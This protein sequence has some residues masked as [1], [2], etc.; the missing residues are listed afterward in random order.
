MKMNIG[1]NIDNEFSFAFSHKSRT[2]E[3]N[4]EGPFVVYMAE[5]FKN[6]LSVQ[7]PGQ[8]L[9]R[10]VLEGIPSTL[11]PNP[12]EILYRHATF[13]EIIGSMGPTYDEK[14][15]QKQM[16]FE[17]LNEDWTEVKAQ[18]DYIESSWS[19]AER[20]LF[21]KENIDTI[22]TVR[23]TIKR[24]YPTLAVEQIE[25]KVAEHICERL[26]P[27]EE[28]KTILALQI[29]RDWPLSLLDKNIARELI[30]LL[31]II[32]WGTDKNI[33]AHAKEVLIENLIFKRPGGKVPF[34]TNIK[35]VREVLKELSKSLSS[36]IKD[37]VKNHLS[38]EIENQ[39][40][41]DVEIQEKIIDWAEKQSD[42]RYSR[43]TLNELRRLYFTP[44][45]YIDCLLINHFGT[46]KRTLDLSLT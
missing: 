30:R 15:L 44:T 24:Q 34:P 39:E 25:E 27:S 10:K 38:I 26:I 7:G 11:A 12:W 29:I 8:L 41:L 22:K 2:S 5:Y 3:P 20:Y 45:E 21:K 23:E 37:Y 36:T 40:E 33:V 13:E 6:S 1:M 32:R 19:P 28:D 4:Q 31:D 43:L 14:N 9:V 46:T 35:L 16:R 17:S 42:H 18:G